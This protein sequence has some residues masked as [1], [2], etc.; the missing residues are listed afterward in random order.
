[1]PEAPIHAVYLLATYSRKGQCQIY[2]DRR[3]PDDL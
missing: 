2:F 3:A 1:M